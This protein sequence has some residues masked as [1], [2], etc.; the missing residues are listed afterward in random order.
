[1]FSRQFCSHHR[2]DKTVGGVNEVLQSH[3][4][5]SM[6]AVYSWKADLYWHRGGQELDSEHCCYD[7]LAVLAAYPD[8]DVVTSHGHVE[9]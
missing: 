9:M 4:H 1:M 6:T 8:V 7:M 2:Q 3:S 5:T